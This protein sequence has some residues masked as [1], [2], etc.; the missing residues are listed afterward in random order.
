M[1]L[2]SSILRLFGAVELVGSKWLTG[3][4]GFRRSLVTKDDILLTHPDNNNM[5]K[6]WNFTTQH[7][8]YV[9][10][11]YIYTQF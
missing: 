6:R 10:W 2:Y 8:R 7:N 3:V 11:N 5:L 4:F 1:L 9:S